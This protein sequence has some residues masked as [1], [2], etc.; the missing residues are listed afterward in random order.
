MERKK[1]VRVGST[2][3]KLGVAAL[4]A[5]AAFDGSGRAIA[6]DTSTSPTSDSGGSTAVEEAPELPGHQPFTTWDEGADAIP[7]ESMSAAEQD[8][9]MHQA[10]LS[11]TNC[12]YDVA[13]KWSVY[14]HEMA[15]L[16]A[17]ETARRLAGLTGT[18]D[19]GVAP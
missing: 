13:Q 17:A 7:F 12:G 3:A 10:E 2:L 16:A 15:E 4:L 18:D 6:Q 5:A 11:E 8:G 9:V 1:S 19:I 14:S